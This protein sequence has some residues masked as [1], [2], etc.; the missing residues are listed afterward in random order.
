[1]VARIGTTSRHLALDGDG[2]ELRF[3]SHVDRPAQVEPR[4]D[5]NY[6]TI[7]AVVPG[8]IE[9][10]LMRSGLLPDP[11]E[12]ESLRETW[13]LEYGDWWYRRTFAVP[14]DWDLSRTSL[15]FD[16][17]DT[18]AEVLLND[19]LVGTADNMMIAHEL[20]T[21]A[22]L[23]HGTNELVVHLT[24]P[25]HAA[26]GFEYPAQL[27]QIWDSMESLWIRKP[28]HMYGW[29]IA[30]RLVSAGI[31]RGVQL[32]E[33]PTERITDWYLVTRSLDA[34]SASVEFQYELSSAP[35][36]RDVRIE[37]LG[38]HASSDKR[39]E[40]TAHPTFVAGHLVFDIADP[41]RWMPRGYGRPELYDVEIVLVVDDVE[42]DRH[43]TRWGLRRIELDSKPA[44]AGGRFRV[45]VNG[46]PVVVLGTN[47]VALDAIHARDGDRL[48]LALT[49]LDESNCNAVRSWG[50]NLY[51]SDAF[52]DWCD[53]HGILV[54]Q[55][56]AFTCARYPQTEPFLSSVRREAESVVRRLRN[57]A[58]LLLWCG[59]NETD[60]SYAD[61]GI[62]PWTDAITRSVLPEI[63]RLHDWRTPY[64]PSSPTLSSDPAERHDVPE[65]HLWGA[66]A[67]FKEP[68]YTDSPAEF[69]S[70]IG[71]HGMPALRSLDR[72]L[73]SIAPAEI[74]TDPVWRLHESHHREH[75]NWYY[76]RNQ[77]LIDQA[78]LYVDHRQDELAEIVLASQICQAE[79]KKFFIEQTRLARGRR[80]GVIWWNLLDS[81]PQISDA[82]VDYYGVRKLAFHYIARAQQPICMIASEARGWQRSLVLVNDGNDEAEV[83][84]RARSVAS[85]GVTAGGV[86]RISPHTSL[87]VAALPL[88]SRGDCHLFEWTAVTQHGSAVGGN[89][90]IEGAPLLAIE[91]YRDVYLPEIAALA[92]T[93]APEDSWR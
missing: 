53:A 26:E 6:R 77:L 12:G 85:G 76:S 80:W 58:S 3:A 81:W 44:D 32:I 78:A 73:P 82:V 33:R 39:F 84:W 66:R 75:P 60:D 49:L 40:A 23:R 34:G 45:S 68:F 48:D 1:M 13:A 88:R 89:H 51:E 69:V 30:P 47:W 18:I 72:F 5:P 43:S 9:L 74:A 90:Y 14:G 35:R 93:F 54:W 64:V 16:G 59:S 25:L 71:Y 8:S 86:S 7:P 24:S 63:V 17:L 67:W 61:D 87:D 28:P 38:V 4:E 10:D 37:I 41:E 92:P 52:F 22:A 42:T 56:F 91:R 57:H 79:A 55:D 46:E 11:F 65:Q 83:T 50:G 2:W 19:V 15:L 70:E 36:S 20:P 29:D 27:T 21:A 62:D 31:F